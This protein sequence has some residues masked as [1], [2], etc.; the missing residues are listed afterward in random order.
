LKALQKYIHVLKPQE[1]GAFE[2]NAKLLRAEFKNLKIK[3][4]FTGGLVHI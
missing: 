1:G 4:D 3:P 2:K